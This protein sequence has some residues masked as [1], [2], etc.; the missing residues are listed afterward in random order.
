MKPVLLDW[1]EDAAFSPHL[2]HTETGK[3]QMQM[4]V[5]M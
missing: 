5:Y 1:N 3:I 4:H 2:G